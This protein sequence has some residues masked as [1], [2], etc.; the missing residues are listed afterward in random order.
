MLFTQRNP[1]FKNKNQLVMI[2]TGGEKRRKL[3]TNSDV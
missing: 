1:A 3:V 2:L